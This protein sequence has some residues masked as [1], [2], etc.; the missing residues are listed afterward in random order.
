M[1]ENEFGRDKKKVIPQPLPFK[2][3]NL[4]V[5]FYYIWILFIFNQTIIVY[6]R[7]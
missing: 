2:R 1:V 6:S 5:F 7:Y 3:N 4:Y